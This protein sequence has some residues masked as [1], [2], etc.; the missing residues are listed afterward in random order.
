M[1][2]TCSPLSSVQMA[3]TT[4]SDSSRTKKLYFC[5]TFDS[6]P[7]IAYCTMLQQFHKIETRLW[8]GTHS[9][10]WM[11]NWSHSAGLPV[12]GAKYKWTHKICLKLCLRHSKSYILSLFSLCSAPSTNE[13]SH[14]KSYTRQ[15][16]V[17][18]TTAN[19]QHHHFDVVMC[20]TF[21]FRKSFQ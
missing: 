15:R 19:F 6:I 4:S 21:F 20:F 17:C 14:T 5:I 1:W 3:K 9:K 12:N 8:E 13:N 16:S 10:N 18:R 7:S 11:W 2:A